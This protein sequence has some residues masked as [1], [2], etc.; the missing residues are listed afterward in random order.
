MATECYLDTLQGRAFVLF[1]TVLMSLQQSVISVPCML[2]L[3]SC[4]HEQSGVSATNPTNQADKSCTF[5]ETPPQQ[6]C[7]DSSEVCY[8]RCVKQYLPVL[9]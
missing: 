2:G 7:C 6:H 4:L 1:F 8:A 5:V 9:I 3:L